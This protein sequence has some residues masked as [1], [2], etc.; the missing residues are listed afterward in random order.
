MGHKIENISRKLVEIN[1]QANDLGL[2]NEQPPGPV[3][4]SLNPYFEEFKIFRRENDEQRIIQL[5]TQ[6]RKEETLTI[7]PIVGMGGVGKTTLAKSIYYNNPKIEHHFDVQAW[8]CVSVKSNVNALL[9][10][11][12]KSLA[13]EECKS[14]MRVNLITNLRNKLG[15][16]RYLLV[17]DEVWNEE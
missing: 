1:K 10:K 12:Y 2:Q 17:L 14:Q 9:A 3:P 16:K 15:S 7:V 5:L 4:G 11:I 6:L 8:V 13:R